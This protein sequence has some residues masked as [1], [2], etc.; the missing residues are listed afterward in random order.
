MRKEI[1]N[2]KTSRLFLLLWVSH[3]HLQA[4]AV[5]QLLERRQQR[6]ILVQLH[7]RLQELDVLQ[8]GTAL[9]VLVAEASPEKVTAYLTMTVSWPNKQH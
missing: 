4:V 5:Q 3:L 8:G 1:G 9:S 2:H 7:R 6:R